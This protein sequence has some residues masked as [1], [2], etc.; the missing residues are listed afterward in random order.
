MRTTD[1]QAD[2]YGKGYRREHINRIFTQHKLTGQI[3]VLYIAI[4]FKLKPVIEAKT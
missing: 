4:D 1:C 3:H 2:R